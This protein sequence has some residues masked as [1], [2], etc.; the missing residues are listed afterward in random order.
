MYKLLQN[1]CV[2]NVI[3]G[4]S[5]VCE[6][7]NPT[8][9]EYLR[10]RDGWT[11]ELWEMQLQDVEK[12][13]E[14]PERL[15]SGEILPDGSYSDS[16]IIPAWTETVTV[17]EYVRV[18]TDTIVHPPHTPEPAD[19]IVIPPITVVSMR[20]ARLQLLSMPFG[21]SHLL[22]VINTA[23]TG[24]SEAAQI[25]WEYS[26]EVRRDNTLFLEIANSLGFTEE[27]I[28]TFFTEASQR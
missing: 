25:E 18:V 9:Q 28:N 10:W 19:P 23:I 26:T 11:E 8:Y 1:N 12:T 24:M 16:E 13:I 7:S 21:N 5:F 15:L 22:S 6:D 2:I 4:V 14:H 20:Q 27:Q 3:T 17:Q